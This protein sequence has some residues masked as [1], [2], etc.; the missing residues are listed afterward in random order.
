MKAKISP[1]QSGWP[2]TADMRTNG[3]VAHH[4]KPMRK[5]QNR[6]FTPQ[7]PAHLDRQARQQHQQ[8]GQYA[9][10]L[11]ECVVVAGLAAQAERELGEQGDEIRIVLGDGIEEKPE[12]CACALGKG[13]FGVILL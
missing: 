3:K 4:E 7:H 1:N 10:Y 12:A 8:A 13:G 2:S 5:Y 6:F 9:E 11:T